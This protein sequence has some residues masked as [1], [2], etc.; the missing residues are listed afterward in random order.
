MGDFGGDMVE[1]VLSLPGEEADADGAARRK[2]WLSDALTRLRADPAEQARI[3]AIA[4]QAG[5]ADHDVQ[6]PLEGNELRPAWLD[7][8]DLTGSADQ[9]WQQVD[10]ELRR[11]AET[12]TAN[13]RFGD[14]LTWL[15]GADKEILAQVPQERGGFIQMA[16]VLLTTAGIASLSM[17]FAL[18]NGVGEPLAASVVLGLL[19]GVV[20]LNL[21]RFLVLSMSGIRERGRLALITLP[22]LALAAVL[23]LVISTPLVLRIFASDINE[24]LFVMQERRA[25]QQATLLAH[26][27][28]AKQA[29]TLEKQINTDESILA[30]HIAGQVTSPQ[31]ES[32]QSQVASLQKQVL[33]DYNTKAAAYNQW[34]CA[35]YGGC[36]GHSSAQGNGPL[37]HAAEQS[38]L[39]ARDN[40]DAHLQQLNNAQS[41]VSTLQKQTNSTAGTLLARQQA[42]AR[43]SLPGLQQQ[44]NIAQQKL[45]NTFQLGGNLNKA[46]TGILAQLEALREVSA[47]NSV[48]ELARLVVLLLFFI[49]EIL[50]V[51][52]KFLLNLG[53]V[54]GYDTAA[55]LK[56]QERIDALTNALEMAAQAHRMKTQYLA[57]AFGNKLRRLTDQ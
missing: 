55:A 5:I 45:Q 10:Q 38:Y 32:A 48:L 6:V 42:Q 28:A 15:G 1:R 57:D 40:Y 24:Q 2:A 3:E 13:T 53:P 44:L 22:R 8:L 46:D 7:E 56:L 52:V 39:Q 23:A 36:P 20:I 50:P 35:L 14:Y 11:T 41:Q 37:A 34:Q 43:R 31:L 51:T 12:P 21:D 29:A 26:S 33:N 16:V 4:I 19:W 9:A 49:I 25:A 47:K 18:Y 17:F 27:A 54:S 30:G